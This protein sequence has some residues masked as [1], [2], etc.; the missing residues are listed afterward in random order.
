MQ[1]MIADTGPEW[2]LFDRH[3]TVAMITDYVLHPF[4]HLTHGH[5][6]ATPGHGPMSLHDSPAM[7]RRI[8]FLDIASEGR[9][10][11]SAWD[12]FAIN[13]T[14]EP[15]FFVDVHLHTREVLQVVDIP[16]G[17]GWGRVPTPSF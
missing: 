8:I 10:L 1:G 16:S 3:K 14:R 11:T 17:S 5:A 13:V 9:R 4:S 2:R 7:K 12:D 15:R 6:H